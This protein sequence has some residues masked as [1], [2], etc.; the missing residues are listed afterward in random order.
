LI[1]KLIKQPQFKKKRLI[2]LDDDVRAVAADA[3]LPVV[4]KFIEI[5]P[6]EVRF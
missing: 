3:L 1:N 4:E 5:C 2:D 6:Y